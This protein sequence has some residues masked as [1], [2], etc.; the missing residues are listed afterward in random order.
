MITCLELNWTTRA[1][2]FDYL[3]YFA[4]ICKLCK[5]FYCVLQEFK[6]W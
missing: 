2:T 3:S 4:S 1:S 5:C 6:L